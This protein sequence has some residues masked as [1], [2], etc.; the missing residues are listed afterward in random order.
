MGASAPLLADEGSSSDE[1]ADER[2]W[3]AR[4]TSPAADTGE[5]KKGGFFSRFSRKKQVVIA[6]P[7][8]PE[9]MPSP[10]EDAGDVEGGG[11]DIG[12]GLGPM[13]S[14]LSVPRMIREESKEVDDD[15]DDDA[16][17]A[18]NN[19]DD[20]NDREDG[21]DEY[22]DDDLEAKSSGRAAD[23]E[24]MSLMRDADGESKLQSPGSSH[25]RT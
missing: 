15:D 19:D 11:Q 24:R 18:S 16:I 1:D 2:Q 4:Q 8:A 10:R 14:S 12:A 9:D 3:A 20:F 6:D 25:S 7:K 13:S 22:G 21:R 23:M 5:P 17:G